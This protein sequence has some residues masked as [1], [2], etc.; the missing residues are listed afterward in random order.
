M[1]VEADTGAEV[2]KDEP[3]FGVLDIILLLA[4]VGVGA[5][6]LLKDKK[7]PE[8]SQTKSYSIQ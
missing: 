3:M 4:L 1:E 8:I 6:W 2:L 5:W 7:K